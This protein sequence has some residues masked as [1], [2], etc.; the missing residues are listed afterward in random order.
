MDHCLTL[1]PTKTIAAGSS[2]FLFGLR[3]RG[4]QS[5]T[6]IEMLFTFGVIGHKRKIE[7]LIDGSVIVDEEVGR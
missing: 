3:D 6:P 7:C 4:L 2:P 5:S 1:I